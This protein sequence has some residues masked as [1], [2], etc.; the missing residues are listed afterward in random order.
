MT[1]VAPKAGWQLEGLAEFIEGVRSR[2]NVPGVSVAVVKDGEVIMS[3]G[4]GYRD[5][6]R[7]LPVT[8]KTI[9][10]HRLVDQ[11]VHYHVAGYPR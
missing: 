11:G 5:L 6:E 2:W 1:V 3:E 4:F 10:A 7:Q 8:T 9:F